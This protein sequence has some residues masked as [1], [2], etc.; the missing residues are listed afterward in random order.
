MPIGAGKRQ[1]RVSVSVLGFRINLSVSL[2]FQ[3]IFCSIVLGRIHC[4]LF[5]PSTLEPENQNRLYQLLWEIIYELS[6][7]L[8]FQAEYTY[9]SCSAGKPTTV[10]TVPK[11]TPQDP[12][13]QLFASFQEQFSVSPGSPTSSGVRKN[14]LCCTLERCML[15]RRPLPL[16]TSISPQLQNR[17]ANHPISYNN[18]AVFGDRTVTISVPYTTIYILYIYTRT[19]PPL[20]YCKY[21]S[22]RMIC[23]LVRVFLGFRWR[24]LLRGTIVNRTYG[25]HKNLPLIIGIDLTVV[26]N[27]IW[28]Y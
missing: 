20:L 2:E 3:T 22:L 8:G 7:L 28:S 10:V 11:Q 23:C 13:P 26:T 12:P 9:A 25:I 21:L 5:R 4:C 24:L 1:C 19:A 15:S 14:A 18:R 6:E 16:C 27:H 17:A